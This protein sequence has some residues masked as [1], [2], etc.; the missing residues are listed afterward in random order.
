M[1]FFKKKRLL[2][3]Q[4]K[5]G[6][7]AKRDLPEDEFAAFLAP[8]WRVLD[9][10]TEGCMCANA[11]DGSTQMRRRGVLPNVPSTQRRGMVLSRA[12]QHSSAH[13]GAQV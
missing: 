4:S 1:F 2:N 12:V 8:L 7:A 11:D 6:K 5:Q 3:A 9:F 13:V 10:S